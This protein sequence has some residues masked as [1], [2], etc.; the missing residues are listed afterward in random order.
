[1]TKSSGTIWVGNRRPEGRSAGTALRNKSRPVG[2]ALLAIPSWVYAQ[3]TTLAQR[4]EELFQQIEQVHHLTPDQMQKLRAIFAGS[5]IIGQGNPAV[6]QHPVTPEQ[7]QAK[8]QQQGV[9]YANAR[10]EK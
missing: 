3:T 5:R 6:T 10:F 2:L 4:N 9:N 1:M 8:L 7:C